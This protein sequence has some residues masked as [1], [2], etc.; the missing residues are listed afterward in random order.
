MGGVDAGMEEG[1][2]G[3]NEENVLSEIVEV[4]KN[5]FNEKHR[6]YNQEEGQM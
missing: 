1:L 4:L 6:D 3:I 2:W 5:V